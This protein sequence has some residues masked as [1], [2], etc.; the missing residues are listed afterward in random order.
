MEPEPLTDIVADSSF[1]FLVEQGGVGQNVLFT[2]V[3][4]EKKHF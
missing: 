1:D 2:Q 4:F 3:S